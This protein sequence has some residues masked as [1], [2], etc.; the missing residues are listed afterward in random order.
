[1]IYVENF[2]PLLVE[3]GS[4]TERVFFS[5]FFFLVQA[6]LASSKIVLCLFESLIYLKGRSDNLTTMS[7]NETFCSLL[8]GGHGL[9]V[10][11][12]KEK[13]KYKKSI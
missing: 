7:K 6:R 3:L 2:F 9:N 12:R 11:S 13:N 8:A 4:K 1:M 5:S 10:V